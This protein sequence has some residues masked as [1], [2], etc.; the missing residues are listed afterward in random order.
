ML[1]IR[2]FYPFRLELGVTLHG[3]SI[4]VMRTLVSCAVK[5]LVVAIPLSFM[6]LVPNPLSVLV[7]LASVVAVELALT[8]VLA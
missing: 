6:T 5:A 4:L 7:A 1:S 2:L 8:L 3:S